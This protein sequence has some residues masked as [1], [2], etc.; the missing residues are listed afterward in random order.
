ME[1]VL[2][3]ICKREISSK[4]HFKAK[5][6]KIKKKIYR[7]FGDP[8]W[9]DYHLCDNCQSSVNDAVILLNNNEHKIIDGWKPIS[10]YCALSHDWVLVK[11]F[12][13]DFECVPVVAER[14]AGKWYDRN[15]NELM[16]EV[17]EFFDFSN[18]PHINVFVRGKR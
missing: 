4:N 13:G 2:C 3:D 15:D 11:M 8:F 7:M 5:G 18:I 16:F 12:D 1:V 6:L 14:R 10:E 9:K 17:R